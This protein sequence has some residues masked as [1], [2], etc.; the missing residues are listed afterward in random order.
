MILSNFQ[1]SKTRNIVRYSGEYT[2]EQEG[3][4]ETVWFEVP[5]Q[6]ASKKF[7]ID[8]F[9]VTAYPMAVHLQERLKIEG[10]ISA[11]L[12]RNLPKVNKKIGLIHPP[13]QIE[14]Q[15]ILE[16]ERTAGGTGQL[17]TL[18]I[19]SF[20]TLVS[21]T[22]DQPKEPHSLIFVNGYDIQ[23]VSRALL[24]QTNAEIQKTAEYFGCTA[25]IVNTNLR[26]VSEPVVDWG[27]YHGAAIAAAGHL[28]SE[29]IH[30]LFFNSST[31]HREKIAWGTSKIADGLWSTEALSCVP[32]GTDTA[33]VKKVQKVV[34]S[35]HFGFIKHRLRVCWENY[36]LPDAPFN[37]SHCEK[38]L[39]TQI[40]LRF[41]TQQDLPTFEALDLQ[42]LEGF[43]IKRQDQY[44][45][46]AIYRLAL[47]YLGE[48]DRITLAIHRL[49][50][51]NRISEKRIV[52]KPSWKDRL[53]H[54]LAK[55]V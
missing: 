19:D 45:W 41:F 9:I 50:K 24:K 48:K 3:K 22:A 8:A 21:H 16:R 27:K 35:P 29:R 44:H 34:E 39:R 13:V 20:F 5:T 7:P 36:G 17:F 12:R 47:R 55:V 53:K 37:C 52:Q 11:M 10:S 46:Q 31:I 40:T 28:F 51:R 18:G 54:F 43:H 14:S 38:C 49:L 1:I 25:L 33:R 26:S 4:T 42:A 6:F 2:F 23:A 30:S 32:F 15:E